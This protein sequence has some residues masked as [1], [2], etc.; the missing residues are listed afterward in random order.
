[1]AVRGARRERHRTSPR[2]TKQ[3]ASLRAEKTILVLL[4]FH[5]DVHKEERIILCD[6]ERGGTT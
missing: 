2:H 1:M 4:L 6:Y 5:G 3:A